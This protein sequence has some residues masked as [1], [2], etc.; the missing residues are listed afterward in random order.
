MATLAQVRNNLSKVRNKN[1]IYKIVLQT[2]K[3]FEAYLIDLNQ[4]QLS[5]GINIKGQKIGQYSPNTEKIAAKENTRQPKT[6]GSDYNFEWSGELF[7]GM[8]LQ[9]DSS[10]FSIFSSAEH[11]TL[12]AEKYGDLF[13]KNS[14]FGLTERSLI[15][16]V[17]EKLI[18]ELQR[19]IC[20]ELKL[21]N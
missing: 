10:T 2:A 20:K 15:E 8:Y 14:I 11:A 1:K 18:P 3:K 5:E 19:E 13:G 12:V 6:A 21:R 7:D 4:I 16:F 9:L 17:Q